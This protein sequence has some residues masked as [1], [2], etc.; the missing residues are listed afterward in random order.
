[1]KNTF[2]IKFLPVAAAMAVLFFVTE[3][4][5]SSEVLSGVAVQP[6]TAGIDGGLA[7]LLLSGLAYAAK[8]IYD[9]KDSADLKN[10]YE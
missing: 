4:A 2:I 10:I 3:T 8:K 9:S 6:E 1:M 7:I 5:V